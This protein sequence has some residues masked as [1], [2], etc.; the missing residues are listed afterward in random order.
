V[1]R[2]RLP[3]GRVLE[4]GSRRLWHLTTRLVA[5]DRVVPHAVGTAADLRLALKSV[6]QDGDITPS[7]RQADTLSDVL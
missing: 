1:I 5:A 2:L 6:G 3:D 7:E 4:I